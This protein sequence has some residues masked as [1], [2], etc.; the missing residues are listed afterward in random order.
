MWQ[1]KLNNRDERHNKIKLQ[2]LEPAK[3]STV[4]RVLKQGSEIFAKP[5]Q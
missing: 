5:Y 4:V 3:H 1:T 2:I